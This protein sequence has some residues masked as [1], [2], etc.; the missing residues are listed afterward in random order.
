MSDNNQAIILSIVIANYNGCDMLYDCI[1]SIYKNPCRYSSEIIVVDDA[2]SDESCDMVKNNFPD[3]I[4]LRNE[5]NLHYSR[6]NNRGI[7][8]ARG[9]YICMLNN[10]TLILPEAMNIMIDFLEAHPKV[11]I[12]G[13]KLLNEDGS[14]QPSVKALPS[15]RT[16]FFGDRSPLSRWFPNNPWTRKELLH[17]SNDMNEPFPAGYV[18]GA[19]MFIRIETI[20]DVGPQDE[21][22]FFIVDADFCSRSWRKGWEVYYVPCAEIIHLNHGSASSLKRQLLGVFE[23]HFGVYCYF[24]KG[25]NSIFHPMLLLIVLGLLVRFLFSFTLQLFQVLVNFL[26]SLK[27]KP[28]D[29]GGKTGKPVI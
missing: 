11:G 8:I 15:I 7:E 29:Q 3:V 24:R 1:K 20:K 4:L 13:S 10:D 14:L 12:A 22:M 9:K 5:V 2:S 18:S 17:L 19:F 25:K 23:F 26:Q 28:V 16:A 27:Y 6:S 21:R